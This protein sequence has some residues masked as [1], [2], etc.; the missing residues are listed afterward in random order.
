MKI[1]RSISIGLMLGLT[2]CA[3]TSYRIH[4]RPPA[5]VTWEKADL[6]ISEVRIHSAKSCATGKVFGT[7]FAQNLETNLFE[8]LC[9]EYALTQ[10]RGISPK[11]RCVVDL[12]T[13][14]EAPG[15]WWLIPTLCSMTLVP[16]M[17]N[18]DE[19]VWGQILVYEKTGN[20]QIMAC[21]IPEYSSR[22]RHSWSITPL[23]F[24]AKRKDA[25]LT[26]SNWKANSSLE[27][28]AM[29]DRVNRPQSMLLRTVLSEI[30][31]IELP[32]NRASR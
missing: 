8:S 29:V 18:V 21:P 6:L 31:K 32:A 20:T 4:P 1:I 25:D 2:G 22:M 24:C 14:V 17:I 23:G 27:Y 13:S 15:K 7:F 28:L 11:Y 5:V 3:S 10:G 26:A 19:K 16:L 12:T 9:H 30:N